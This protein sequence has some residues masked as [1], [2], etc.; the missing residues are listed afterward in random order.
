[1]EQSVILQIKKPDLIYLYANYL[2]FDRNIRV[3][4]EN[5]YVEIQNR[6]LQNISS[7]AEDRYE[8]F[9]KQYPNLYARLPNTQ[10]A[11]YLGITPELL[12]KIRNNISKK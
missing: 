9:L 4:I 5:K 1:M 12:S 2:K 7:N 6:L 8:A 3:I 10:I 11:S